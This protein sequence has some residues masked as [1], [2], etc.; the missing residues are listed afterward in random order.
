MSR[1][2]RS[3]RASSGLLSNP[4]VRRA[5]A[6]FLLVVVLPLL[7]AA[8][9]ALVRVHDQGT[10]TAD[11][12]RQGTQAL[13][14]RMNGALLALRGEL[15]AIKQL[16]VERRTASVRRVDGGRTTVFH[17]PG[18]TP[19][20]QEALY[21]LPRGEEEFERRTS[22]PSV[23]LVLLGE[24]REQGLYMVTSLRDATDTPGFLMSQ[25]DLRLLD[26]DTPEWSSVACLLTVQGEA[27]DCRGQPPAAVLSAYPGK[28]SSLAFH[29]TTWSAEGRTWA[30][31][32]VRLET[33]GA[34][35]LPALLMFHAVPEANLPASPAL[36]FGAFT[37]AIL[38]SLTLLVLLCVG[39][40]WRLLN[41]PD[42]RKAL[43][44][45]ALAEQAEGSGPAAP[46]RPATRYT[47]PETLDELDRLTLTGQARQSV[48]DV[49][50]E[51]MPA[52]SACQAVAIIRLEDTRVA[53]VHW[54][55]EEAPLDSSP[56]GAGTR[57]ARSDLD[58]LERAG[59]CLELEDCAQAAWARPLLERGAERL[60]VLPI[61]GVGGIEAIIT[62]LYR[63][64][65]WATVE[66]IERARTLAER[67]AVALSN[68]EWQESVYQRTHY[69][70]VTKLPNR[71]L[72][73]SRLEQALEQARRRERVV[74]LLSVGIDWSTAEATRVRAR[75]GEE[76]LARL[77]R[78]LRESLEEDCS[79]ARVGSDTFAVL[80]PDMASQELALERT[81]AL[82]ETL[83]AGLAA[84]LEVEGRR[85][86]PRPS[87]GLAF[88]PLDAVAR[89]E[90]VNR[91]EQ[92][93]HQCRQ[94]RPGG[95]TYCSPELN[96]S[97]LQ[98]TELAAE[99]EGAL[100]RGELRLHL[101]P[102][103][104]CAT[105]AVSG[106]EALLR[107]QHPRLGMVAPARFIPLAEQ[108][109]RMVAFGAW[110]LEQ[111]CLQ[112]RAWQARGLEGLRLSVNLSVTQLRS[113]EAVDRLCAILDRHPAC[114]PWLELEVTE[115][116]RGEAPEK[117]RAIFQRLRSRGVR[118]SVDDFG[119]GQAAMSWLRE[120]PVDT[121]KLD[122]S[123]VR[124]LPADS[125]S[126]SCSAA[127]VALA[128]SLGCAV[129]AEGVE[130]EAQLTCLQELGCE[131]A[132]GRFLAEPMPSEAFE[133]FLEAWAAPAARSLKMVSG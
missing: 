124:G 100:E 6:I 3:R 21:D 126:R 9:L 123:I 47:L 67:A 35:G 97:A 82:T 24:G 15:L 122:R 66:A 115:S 23:A 96:A 130:N 13:G 75:P 12:L 54:R 127:T 94:E 69:D 111:A 120:V 2:R 110:A 4:L 89:I 95:W 34:F 55:D 103:I 56:L 19:P 113:A 86:L 80:V 28:D 1:H 107:W 91:A 37:P 119:T 60:V 63:S 41:P 90:L 18:L 27:L 112:L 36:F 5:L 50:L 40:A 39:A 74:G 57:I 33:A 20:P 38:L 133:G 85:W 11:Q 8:E 121:I 42:R 44:R 70:A 29:S 128:T 26:R 116:G 132:Q 48:V 59:G 58:A 73:T 52:L 118:I 98:R 101:Q 45:L 105:G 17:L 65:G 87:V 108:T 14:E 129:V 53:R 31:G 81:Q 7:L 99:L 93:M 62:L 83:R 32:F 78:L 114:A 10:H 125:Y 72:F 16:P 51:R 106:A 49:L 84:G 61:N 71:Q 22:G 30:G 25:V 88:Y 117:V 109:G 46:Q 92:A 104:C 43:G 102:Q 76:V 131:R 64:R 77:A 79:L 68:G